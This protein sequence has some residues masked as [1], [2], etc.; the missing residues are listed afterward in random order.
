MDEYYEYTNADAI[1]EK[2]KEGLF[3]RSK[4]NILNQDQNEE[5]YKVVRWIVDCL[6][7]YSTIKYLHF[8]DW[9]NQTGEMQEKAIDFLFRIKK[10]FNGV[11]LNDD[12]F[13]QLANFCSVMHSI[14]LKSFDDFTDAIKSIFTDAVCLYVIHQKTMFIF[15][16]LSDNILKILQGIIF[17]KIF[18]MIPVSAYCLVQKKHY[19]IADYAGYDAEYGLVDILHPISSAEDEVQYPLMSAED[20]YYC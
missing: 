7:E 17:Y 11:E 2:Q 9:R 10:Q 13:T 5:N 19:A 12:E 1:V 16:D 4:Y 15:L 6:I 20:M 3:E 18:P 8:L 14:N